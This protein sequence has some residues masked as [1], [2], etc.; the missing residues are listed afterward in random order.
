MSGEETPTDGSQQPGAQ[1]PAP[2]PDALWRSELNRHLEDARRDLEH[3]RADIARAKLA[4]DGDPVAE[5]R[6]GAPGVG[7]GAIDEVQRLE[8]RVRDLERRL[9]QGPPR[10]TPAATPTGSA[11][12]DVDS[13]IPDLQPVVVTD[14]SGAEEAPPAGA[15]PAAPSDGPADGGVESVVPDLQKGVVTDLSGALETPPEPAVPADQPAGLEYP[16]SGG[17]QAAPPPEAS[18][19]IPGGK[20]TVVAGGVGAATALGAAAVLLLGGGGGGAATLATD[21][22]PST[23]TTPA[24]AAPAN[25]APAVT[26]VSASFHKTPPPEQPTSCQLGCLQVKPVTVRTTTYTVTASDPEGD[27]LTYRW[28]NTNH[29][30]TFTADGPTARW[31]FPDPG[32]CPAGDAQAGTVTVTVSDGRHACTAAYPGGSV[33]GRG[34]EAVCTPT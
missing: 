32:D 5:Q 22:A 23:G 33:S 20:K 6:T 26:P 14:L 13:V 34:R 10:P 31:D 1:P 30:G 16:D 3:F 4:D 19:R 25:Q 12:P 15:E 8:R 2:D 28:D 24:A 11:A 21:T 18:R 27:P 17:T 9:A 7:Q 29:C